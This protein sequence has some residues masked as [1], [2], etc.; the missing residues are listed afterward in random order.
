MF[1]SFKEDKAIWQILYAIPRAKDRIR[2]TR[3]VR[4]AKTSRTRGKRRKLVKKS[5]PVG[6]SPSFVKIPKQKF[7]AY[8][9]ANDETGVVEV[10]WINDND[11]F[12]RIESWEDAL[13]LSYRRAAFCRFRN[14]T[15]KKDRNGIEYKVRETV[16]DVF[17]I[18]KGGKRFYNPEFATLD[19]FLA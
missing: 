5:V 13:K 7:C 10:C 19:Q 17:W 14:A 12:E 15:H 9:N 6:P 1:E 8:S 16:F 2:E 18:E 11:T 3:L 4:E